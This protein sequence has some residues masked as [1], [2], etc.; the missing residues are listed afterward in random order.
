[1]KTNQDARGNLQKTILA[2]ETFEKLGT[3]GQ[4]IFQSEEGHG[5]IPR[6]QPSLR[7]AMK[8]LRELYLPDCEF[9]HAMALVGSLGNSFKITETEDEDDAWALMWFTHSRPLG[10]RVYQS[11]KYFFT[12]PHLTQETGPE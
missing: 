12:M 7:K 8:E 6:N 3:G 10:V 5:D 1:M 9:N 4:L 11:P 2:A